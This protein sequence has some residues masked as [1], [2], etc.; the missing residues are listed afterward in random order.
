MRIVF[1][2]RK[3]IILK[4]IMPESIASLR[5]GGIHDFRAS[6]LKSR[7]KDRLLIKEE[8]LEYL[9]TN[10]FKIGHLF[11]GRSTLNS[12][13]LDTHFKVNYRRLISK[14][15]GREEKGEKKRK[16]SSGKLK[17]AIQILL[18]VRDRE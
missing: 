16:S 1:A 18:G 2:I 4:V 5:H 15:T 9:E 7:R 8:Y 12:S 13:L 6:S 3:V 11:V 14:W 10:F 17:R